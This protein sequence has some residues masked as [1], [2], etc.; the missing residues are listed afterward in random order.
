MTEKTTRRGLRTPAYLRVVRISI[1]SDALVASRDIARSL[2]KIIASA[3]YWI[4]VGADRTAG[5]LLVRAHL[6]NLLSFAAPDSQ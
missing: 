4:S 5:E 2:R 1:A 3:D 6:G